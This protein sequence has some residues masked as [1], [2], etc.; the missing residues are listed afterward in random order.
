MLNKSLT[1]RN[2]ILKKNQLHLE[3]LNLIHNLLKQ[4]LELILVLS[5]NRLQQNHLQLLKT[6]HNNLT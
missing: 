1:S 3:H 2:L 4:N 6:Q 5:E